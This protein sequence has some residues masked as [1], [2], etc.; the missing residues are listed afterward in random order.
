MELFIKKHKTS[1]FLSNYSI[2]ESG[3]LI[4]SAKAKL[5]AEQP[6]IVLYNQDKLEIGKINQEISVFP[7]FTLSFDGGF[8]TKVE[9]L[10]TPFNNLILKTPTGTI[11]LHHQKGLRIA[12][13][14]NENQIAV[15][16]R[17]RFNFLNA[18]GYNLVANSNISKEF[19]ILLI[20]GWDW[21]NNY[22]IKL[23][24]VYFDYIGLVKQ[25]EETDW[26]PK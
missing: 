14:E 15:V 4:F 23:L 19:L 17:E 16:K 2:F 10:R 6:E 18:T 21:T 24:P 7:E 20:I 22:K 25:N 9:G 1:I 11:E 13:F 3:K 26:N 8:N 12:V 5:F